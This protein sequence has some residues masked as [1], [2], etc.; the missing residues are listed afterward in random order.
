MITFIK[1]LITCNITMGCTNCSHIR[2]EVVEVLY[3]D[4]GTFFT[5]SLIEYKCLDCIDIQ[6][7]RPTIFRRVQVTMKNLLLIDLK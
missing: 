2:W 3:N 4:E 5:T 6:T 7:N 1:L